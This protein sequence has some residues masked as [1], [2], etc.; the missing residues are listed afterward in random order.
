MSGVSLR[1]FVNYD[2]GDIRWGQ[3]TFSELFGAFGE[4]PSCMLRKDNWKLIYY[5]E[6]DSCQLF[7]LAED[8]AEVNDLA[9]IPEYKAVI[10]E[11]LANIHARWSAERMI[12]GDR[13]EHLNRS[14]IESCGH[15]LFPHEISDIPAPEGANNFDYSQIPFSESVLSRI[16]R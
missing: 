6:Y 16:E 7:N 4:K 12:E 3:E 10:D 11:M 15:D 9:K 1:P 8:Q 2:E 5:S 13:K 14:I